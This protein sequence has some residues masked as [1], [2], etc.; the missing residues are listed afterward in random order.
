[1]L[2]SQMTLDEEEQVQRE[3]E[4]L[5]AEAIGNVVRAI[6]L[7]P[8]PSNEKLMLCQHSQRTNQL[9]ASKSNC[10]QYPKDSLPVSISRCPGSY[11]ADRILQKSKKRSQ[12]RSLS[13]VWQFLREL[14]MYIPLSPLGPALLGCYSLPSTTS[15]L[16]SWFSS[17]I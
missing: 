16:V 7:S 10:H 3:L 8:P 17:H 9:V 11:L 12:L 6:S 1:M 13:A 14:V 2:T 15:N 5:Q 4:Q